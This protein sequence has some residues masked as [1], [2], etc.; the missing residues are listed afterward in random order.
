MPPITQKRPAHR[1]PPLSSAAIAAAGQPLSSSLSG[2]N[3]APLVDALGRVKA[4]IAPLAKEEKTLKEQFSAL[5][6]GIYCGKLFD[7]SVSF[8]ERETLDAEMVAKYL[9]AAQLKR[10]KKKSDIVTVRV[11]AR[12]ARG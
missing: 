10:C 12:V 7:A 4:Q 1:M 3:I 6:E 5:G 8:S 2:S 9:T 11:T